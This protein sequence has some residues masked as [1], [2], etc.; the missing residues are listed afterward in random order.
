MA[1]LLL[2]TVGPFTI[3][4]T[5]NPA[6]K[7]TSPSKYAR[8]K[9]DKTAEVTVTGKVEE[10]EEFDCPVTNAMGSHVVLQT[11]DSSILVHVAPVKFMKQYGIEL[12]KGAKLTV[13][14]AR[15]KDGEG[16]DTMLAREIQSDEIV[17]DVRTPDG[18]P[19][20]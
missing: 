7:S 18:R 14:G 4:Q 15:L 10:I 20:W 5:Q 13:T 12:K 11:A 16:G 9:Y 6:P 3:A 19:L 8:L 1:L 2:A 17:L